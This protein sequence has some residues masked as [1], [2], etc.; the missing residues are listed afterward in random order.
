MANIRVRSDGKLY[1]DFQYKT[2]RCREY[3]K[4]ND[5]KA[6]R[7]RMETVLKRIVALIELDQFNYKEFFPTGKRVAQFEQ[8]EKQPVDNKVVPTF[9][10]FTEQWYD[11][12]SIGWRNSYKRVISSMLNLRLIPAF[13][14]KKICDIQKTGVLQFRA[15][16]A[17]VTT[18][19]NK[20][21]SAQHINR[22]I[23]VLK[24]IVNEAADR[25]NFNSL[26]NGIKPLK[27]QKTDIKPFTLQEVRQI[28]DNVRF[29]FKHYYIV[30]FFTGMRTAEIDGLQWRY[31]DFERGEILI[32]E[33][34]VNGEIEYTKTDGSQR[35]IK[36]TCRTH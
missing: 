11:E 24:M 7:K 34:L 26:I 35:A 13:G 4:L 9:K 8:M 14:D 27:T 20:T 36:M 23:K 5:T 2:V 29:D 15:S 28:I 21:I 30:R 22:H 31:V 25:H 33:T 1:F 3:S 17:K 12:M 6:N 18:G 19:K 16:L 32:R 10:A